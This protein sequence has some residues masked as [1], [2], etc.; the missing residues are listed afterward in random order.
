MGS[1]SSSDTSPNLTT[2]NRSSLFFFFIIFFNLSVSLLSFCLYLSSFLS[3]SIFYHSSSFFLLHLLL[4]FV[5]IPF[6]LSHAQ[7]NIYTFMSLKSLLKTHDDNNHI[8]ISRW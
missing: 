5:P 3:F 2:G 8:Y 1:R 6:F 7:I 4:S